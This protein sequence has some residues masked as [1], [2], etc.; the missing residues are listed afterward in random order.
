MDIKLKAR[1]LAEKEY[2]TAYCYTQESVNDYLAAQNGFVAGYV[3]CATNRQWTDEDMFEAWQ[4]GAIETPQK[5][6][7]TFDE[8]LT[9]FKNNKHEIQS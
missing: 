1:A 9:K 3:A 7:L 2:N 4:Q 6:G 5:L 8:W